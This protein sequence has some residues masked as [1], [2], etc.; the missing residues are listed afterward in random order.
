MSPTSYS[1]AACDPLWQ[2]A[3]KEELSALNKTGTWDLVLPPSGEKIIGC[4]W[5]YKI[6]RRSDSFIERY[7]ARLVAKGFAQEYGMDYEET[8]ALVAIQ[9]RLIVGS[10]V[11]L[12]ITRSD[13]AYAVH[14]VSQFVCAPTSVHW[15]AVMRILSYLRGT[16]YQSVLFLSTSDLELRAFSDADWASGQTDRKSTTGYCIF[17]G[18]SLISWKSKKQDVVSRSFT[19]AE[20]RAMASTTYEIVCYDGC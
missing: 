10:L 3:M 4:R 15:A 19:E 6:K 11:Y 7:K 14:I 20:Y 2:E 1:E 17:I 18:D 16:L 12:T 5:M 9:I 8:F 13:I